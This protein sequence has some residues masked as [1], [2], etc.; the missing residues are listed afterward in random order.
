MND[1]EMFIY[2]NTDV[3]EILPDEDDLNAINDFYEAHQIW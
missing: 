3:V 2:E 1:L